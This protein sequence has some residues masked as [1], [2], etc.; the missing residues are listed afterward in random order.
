MQHMLGKFAHMLSQLSLFVFSHFFG[1]W[2]DTNIIRNTEDA[3]E[4]TILVTK[5]TVIGVAQAV[6]MTTDR[7][8]PIS[9]RIVFVDGVGDHFALTFLGGWDP[10]LRDPG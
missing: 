3:A 5:D 2:P 4:T 6:N 8:R 10:V 7:D 9:G 1:G